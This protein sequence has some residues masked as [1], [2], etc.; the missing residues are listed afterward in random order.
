MAPAFNK[1]LTRKCSIESFDTPIALRRRTAG[2]NTKKS[3]LDTLWSSYTTYI[4]SFQK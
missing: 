1:D 3:V 4:F 2:K